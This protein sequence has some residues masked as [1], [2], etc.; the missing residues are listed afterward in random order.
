MF[1]FLNSEYLDCQEEDLRMY[2]CTENDHGFIMSVFRVCVDYIL[3]LLVVVRSD[4]L[5][6]IP[7]ALLP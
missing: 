6:S 5:P 2:F 7:A 3:C 4:L 1:E